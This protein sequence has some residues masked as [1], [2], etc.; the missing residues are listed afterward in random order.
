MTLDHIGAYFDFMLPDRVTSVLRMIGRAAAVLFMFALVVGA[1]HTSDRKKYLLRLYICNILIAIASVPL[2]LGG[3]MGWPPEMIATLFMTMLYIC[4]IDSFIKSSK[5]AHRLIYLLIIASV[6]ILPVI[7]DRTLIESI[8]HS[9]YTIN[10]N[11]FQSAAVRYILRAILPN[12]WTIDYSAVFVIMGILMYYFKNKYARCLIVLL[13]SMT[14][15][16]G[17]YLFHAA[18]FIEFFMNNQYY[19]FLA[20]PFIWAYNGEKGRSIKYL[21]YIYYPAH[22]FIFVL[23]SHY[24]QMKA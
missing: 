9:V 3:M 22:I 5:P 21:Y 11:S 1:E 14:S 24:L 7:I 13:A 23:L 18:M 15:Y 6:T 19:M 20:I 8:S 12:M 16:A 2:I 10:N 17:T 4:L